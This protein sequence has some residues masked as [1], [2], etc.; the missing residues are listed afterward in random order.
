MNLHWANTYLKTP[1]PV[2]TTA[3]NARGL[4]PSRYRDLPCSAQLSGDTYEPHDDFRSFPIPFSGSC[5]RNVTSTEQERVPRAQESK[6]P[7]EIMNEDDLSERKTHLTQ[8]SRGK[9]SLK[10]AKVVFSQ[11]EILVALVREGKTT[12]FLLSFLPQ[13]SPLFLF[14]A[15]HVTIGM[16]NRVGKP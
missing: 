7:L 9:P 10:R 12:T 1:N 5:D 3:E 8:V 6:V 16:R 15:R 14:Q 4:R 13:Q 2:Q 11:S